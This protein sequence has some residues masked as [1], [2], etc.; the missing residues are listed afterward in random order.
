LWE[1]HGYGVRWATEWILSVEKRLFEEG[2]MARRIDLT[3]K[4]VKARF[5][6]YE[7]LTQMPWSWDSPPPPEGGSSRILL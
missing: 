5:V 1:K 2:V 7:M 4:E 6:V 3:H